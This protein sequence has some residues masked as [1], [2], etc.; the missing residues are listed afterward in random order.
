MATAQTSPAK[1]RRN[2]AIE[3]WRFLASVIIVGYHISFIFPRVELPDS[4]SPSPWMVGGGEVLF[5]FTLTMGYFLN[6][7]YDSRIRK[8]SGYTERS[9]SSRAWEY[10]AGRLRQLLPTLTLGIVL[11]IISRALYLQSSPVEVLSQV[12]N[13]LWEF[14]GVYI[15]GFT[16]A[17]GQSNGAMWFIS[18]LFICS[19][20]LYWAICHN[21][22]LT[23]GVIVPTI[24]FVLEGWWCAT[25][26]RA[27]QKAF[28]SFGG[29]WQTNTAVNGAAGDLT[30]AVG[31]NNGLIFV[32]VGMCGGILIY[33]AVKA[34][35]E[36]E[37]SG[38]AKAWL[39]ILYAVVGI[40]LITY[41]LNPSWYAFLGEAGLSRMTIHLFVIIVVFL[42]LLGVDPVSRAINSDALAPALTYL[43]KISL[44]I[45]MLHQPMII[46][47]VLALGRSTMHSFGDLFLPTMALTV[48]GSIALQ[49]FQ[50]RKKKAKA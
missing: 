33:Q 47:S 22:D 1:P 27:S 18:A 26:I 15:L 49:A 21:E 2:V 40:V 11:G 13:G 45:Y 9:A 48:A 24:F 17:Y 39:G 43:G 20:L 46:F 5:I 3:F 28:S 32:L 14:L 38:A 37:F 44:N 42:S 30:Y 8:V 31:I 16:A 35:K 25:G 34:L 4:V 12:V 29:V 23:I 19:Y 6:A 10:L 41:M 7:H 36:H 50:D